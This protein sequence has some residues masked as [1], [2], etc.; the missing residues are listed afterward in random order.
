MGAL[1][2]S[3]YSQKH[4]LSTLPSMLHVSIP[5]CKP[6]I[7]VVVPNFHWKLPFCSEIKTGR[8]G[9]FDLCLTYAVKNIDEILL[10]E[11]LEKLHEDHEKFQLHYVLLDPPGNWTGDVGYITK[12]MI[13]RY[14]PPPN[15]DSLVVV[16][17]PPPFCKAMSIHLENLGYVKGKTYYSYL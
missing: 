8:D 6:Y 13:D 4:T 3:Q 2:Y 14:M 12:D 11:T 5:S 7:F 15:D 1:L 10:R 17:G 9:Y 16:C